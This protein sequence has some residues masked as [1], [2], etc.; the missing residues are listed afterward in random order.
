L[1]PRAANSGKS[2]D[3]IFKKGLACLSLDQIC[4]LIEEVI[5]KLFRENVPLKIRLYS[6]KERERRQD[7]KQEQYVRKIGGTCDV[8]RQWSLLRICELCMLIGNRFNSRQG[9]Q[10][11]RN[12]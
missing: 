11:S 5:S 4:D 12:F 2:V 7:L 8:C 10:K 3:T 9:G 1:T 6:S